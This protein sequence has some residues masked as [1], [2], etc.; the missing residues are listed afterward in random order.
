M[1]RRQRTSSKAVPPQRQSSRLTS[2]TST[3]EGGT[4]RRLLTYPKV[5]RVFWMAFELQAVRIVVF[6]LFETPS[7]MFLLR[8]WCQDRRRR[9]WQRREAGT[10]LAAET[11]MQSNRS[12]RILFYRIQYI[13]TSDSCLLSILFYYRKLLVQVCLVG[14]KLQWP[15]VKADNY[16]K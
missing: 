15:K 16:S 9:A 14:D 11:E 12:D 7:R 2:A 3:D 1:F 4:K 5:S 6:L 13:N 8:T 10:P